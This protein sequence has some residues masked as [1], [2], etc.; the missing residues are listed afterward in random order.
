M[1]PG[2]GGVVLCPATR[3]SPCPPPT[4][5]QGRTR[6][7]WAFL[8]PRRPRPTSRRSILTWTFPASGPPGLRLWGRRPVTSR[9]AGAR[10]PHPRRREKSPPGRGRNRPQVAIP[11]APP[12]QA[13]GQG[14]LRSRTGP[15]HRP[16]LAGRRRPSPLPRRRTS[17]PRPAVGGFP[18]GHRCRLGRVPAVRSR[19]PGRAL[20]LR[21]RAVTVPAIPRRAYTAS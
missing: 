15:P 14:S 6:P 8:R 4:P 10:R 9:S 20:T 17:G 19:R 1:P 18:E 2:R 3:G 12:R 16:D 7:R 11:L 13:P 21:D 5:S